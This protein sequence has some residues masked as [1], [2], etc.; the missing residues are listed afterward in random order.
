MDQNNALP[1]GMQK[2][3]VDNVAVHAWTDPHGQRWVGV[4]AICA[5]VGLDRNAQLEVLTRCP[6][7]RE[8]AS[9]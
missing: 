8:E 9:D 4:R 5:W 7:S 1:L 2:I 6:R 3:N